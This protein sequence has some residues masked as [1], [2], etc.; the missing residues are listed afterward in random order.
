VI[1]RHYDDLGKMSVHE[2]SVVICFSVLILLWF[3][4]QPMFIKGWGQIL[5]RVTDR[6]T[7]AAIVDATP[8][9]L[10][11]IMVFVLPVHYRFWPFQ[12][13]GVDPKKSPS[14]VTWKVI[15]KKMPWGVLLFVGGGFAISDACT[16]TGKA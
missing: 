1:Q 9:I 2:W 8:A 3:F 7:N 11:V 5:M 10:M 6:G 12:P 16:K 4:R 13:M 14:L 15:E